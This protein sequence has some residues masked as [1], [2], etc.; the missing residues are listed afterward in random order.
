MALTKTQVSE[1]YVAIFGRASEREGNKYWQT[2]NG[3]ISFIA[4]YAK[5]RCSKRVF[6]SYIK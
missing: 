4:N 3:D 5:Y 2:I 6:W 1:L